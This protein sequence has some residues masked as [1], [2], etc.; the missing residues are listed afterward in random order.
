[1]VAFQAAVRV[2]LEFLALYGSLLDPAVLFL[3]AREQVLYIRDTFAGKVLL[4]IIYLRKPAFAPVAL[5]P[6]P[7][8][9]MV[10]AIHNSRRQP[11]YR[12][13]LMAPQILPINI[14][15]RPISIKRGLHPSPPIL[16]N[17]ALFPIKPRPESTVPAPL[18]TFPFLTDPI[19]LP[20]PP[21]TNMAADS[22]IRQKQHLILFLQTVP[23][24]PTFRAAFFC[25]YSFRVQYILRIQTI[26]D[27]ILVKL[28]IQF[29]K[30]LIQIHKHFLIKK[31]LSVF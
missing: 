5:Q 7:I 1:M 10:F 25:Q 27:N 20:P 6:R 31:N 11:L 19:F 24:R 2:A 22:L 3:G 21:F 26:P 18:F 12:M 17:D 9:S 15:H 8:I 29:L 13:Q 28:D 23:L 4:F 14:L 30:I 16:A